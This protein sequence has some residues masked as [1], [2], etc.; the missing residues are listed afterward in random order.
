MQANSGLPK[1]VALYQWTGTKEALEA[2]VTVRVSELVSQAELFLKPGEFIV[3][4]RVKIVQLPDFWECYV[5]VQANWSPDNRSIT[6][7]ISAF[8]NQ[9]R[10]IL[11]DAGAKSISFT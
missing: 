11:R 8:R 7:Y 4:W 2:Y 3:D 1:T 5:K 6:S 9:L 10:S